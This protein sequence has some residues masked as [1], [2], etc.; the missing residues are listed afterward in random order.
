MKRPFPF[1]PKKQ[2]EGCQYEI[3]KGVKCGVVSKTN[4][5]K[6]NGFPPL[7]VEHFEI[8]LRDWAK[9]EAKAMSREKR[10]PE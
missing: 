10:L 8:T 5:P 6:A 2:P 9:N 7:C 3:S 1:A 4:Y